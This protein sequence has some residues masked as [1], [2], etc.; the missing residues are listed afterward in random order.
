MDKKEQQD[1]IERLINGWAAEVV[2]LPG[3]QR[4]AALQ[5]IRAN[6]YRDAKEAGASDEAAQELSN[7]MDEFTRALIRLIVE[8]GGATGGIA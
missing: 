5:R 6:N 2:K 7:K 4:E 3:D 1:R 8:R